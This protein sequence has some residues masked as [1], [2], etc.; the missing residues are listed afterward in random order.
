MPRSKDITT[1]REKNIALTFREGRIFSRGL[2]Y[3]MMSRATKLE[4]VFL[5]NPL[6][7]EHF[8]GFES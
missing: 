1:N 6:R 2:E 7:P 5:L 3:V 4:D 8:T